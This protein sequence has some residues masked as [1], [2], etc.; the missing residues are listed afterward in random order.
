MCLTTMLRN[1]ANLSTKATSTTR[2]DASCGVVGRHLL[3]AEDVA[4]LVASDNQGRTDETA[5]TP[6]FKRKAERHMKCL[7]KIKGCS[8]ALQT[9]GTTLSE[10]QTML[11]MLAADVEKGGMMLL[12]HSTSAI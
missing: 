7:K 11:D 5:F 10:C 1:A 4:T 3:I 12:V 2:W 8:G 6:S 9:K